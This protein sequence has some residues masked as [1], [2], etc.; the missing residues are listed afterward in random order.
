MVP[1]FSIEAWFSLFF[2]EAYEYIG[3]FRELYEAFVLSSFVY[4]IIELL[5]GEDELV[6]KL[7]RKEVSYGEHMLPFKL[8][9]REWKMGRQ[10]MINCKYGVVSEYL[11][12][13]EDVPSPSISN[14]HLTLRSPASIRPH[15][16]HCNNSYHSI[17]SKRII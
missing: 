9:L 1:I 3:V 5:G 17:A 13:L 4:Y 15:Q 11:F 2:H 16:D 10:F 12:W 6:L 8:W 14:E 7:R